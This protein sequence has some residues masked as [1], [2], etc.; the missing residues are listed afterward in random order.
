[1]LRVIHVY[2]FLEYN[3]GYGNITLIDTDIAYRDLK[4][5]M[6]LFHI[7]VSTSSLTSQFNLQEGSKISTQSQTRIKG[8]L[9]GLAL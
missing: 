4:K 1:M 7:S 2:L 9:V 8:S 5:Y 6:A 3:F